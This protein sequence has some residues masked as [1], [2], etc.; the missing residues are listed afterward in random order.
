MIQ[1]LIVAVIIGI[2]VTFIVMKFFFNKKDSSCDKCRM[3]DK[4]NKPK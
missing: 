4:N 3:N 1:E 2:S